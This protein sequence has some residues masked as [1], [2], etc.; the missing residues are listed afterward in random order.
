[1]ELLGDMGHVESRFGPFRDS[2][3]V[4]A[5]KVHGLRQPYQRIRNHFGCT[6]WYSK[7]TRLKWMLVSFCLEILLT[8]TQIGARFVSNI[9]QAQISFWMYLKELLGDVGHVE[10]HFGLFG[11]SVNIDAR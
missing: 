1:M 8:M 4:V 5:R 2:A 11:D 9:P 10:S 6:R 7:V 3:S